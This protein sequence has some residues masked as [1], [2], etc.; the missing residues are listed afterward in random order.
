MACVRGSK[1]TSYLQ[2]TLLEQ[3]QKKKKKIGH[4]RMEKTSENAN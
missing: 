4:K 1:A 3:Q 2:E